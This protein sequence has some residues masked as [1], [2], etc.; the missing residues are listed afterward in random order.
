MLNFFAKRLHE[1]HKVKR[2]ELRFTLI[3]FLVVV[4]IIGILAAI[5]IPVFLAQS[6]KAEIATC[7]SDARN[8]AGA[9]TAYLAGPGNGSFVGLDKPALEAQGFNPTDDSAGNYPV[10]VS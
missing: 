1:L 9:A 7:A 10:S 4:I 2:E 5:A 6:R 3:E 8:A